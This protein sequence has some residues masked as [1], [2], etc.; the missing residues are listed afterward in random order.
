[1]ALDTIRFDYTIEDFRGLPTEAERMLHC[2]FS[3]PDAVD[4]SQADTL[5]PIFE[6]NVYI[7][8]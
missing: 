7:N 1:M 5:L 8:D 3:C 2:L 4:E 6:I